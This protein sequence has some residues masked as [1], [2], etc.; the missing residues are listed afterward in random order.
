VQGRNTREVQ[1]NLKNFP[2]SQVVL[3]E[4]LCLDP[5]RHFGELFSFAGLDWD[6]H[7]EEHVAK[8]TS[9]GDRTDPYSTSRLSQSMVRA[10]IDKFTPEALQELRAGYES[11]GLPWYKAPEDWAA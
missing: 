2:S 8:A 6:A 4:E 7:I 5:L 1:E 10:W 9:G 11:C 3:Y